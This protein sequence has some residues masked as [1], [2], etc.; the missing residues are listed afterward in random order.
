VPVGSFSAAGGPSEGS[1]AHR[2]RTLDDDD[3]EMNRSDRDAACR[4]A[5]YTSGL[6]SRIATGSTASSAFGLARRGFVKVKLLVNGSSK[7][8]SW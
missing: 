6:A 5:T 4:P 3:E 1:G 7:G 8:Q 2:R